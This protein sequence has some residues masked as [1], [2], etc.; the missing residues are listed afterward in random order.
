MHALEE[1][2]GGKVA[3]EL[4]IYWTIRW[5]PVKQITIFSEIDV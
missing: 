2:G 5:T 3:G 1:C 4:N